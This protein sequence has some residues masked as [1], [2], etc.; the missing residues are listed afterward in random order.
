VVFSPP[1][2]GRDRKSALK[3]ELDPRAERNIVRGL[4]IVVDRRGFVEVELADVVFR[5]QP[6]ADIPR[7]RNVYAG[8]SVERRWAS[9]ESATRVIAAAIA[10]MPT[11]FLIIGDPPV[12]GLSVA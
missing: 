5:R 1:N 7:E 4:R 10:A 3:S 6:K 12:T 2:K 11:N 8:T 9:A